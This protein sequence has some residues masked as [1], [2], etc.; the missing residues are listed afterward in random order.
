[1]SVVIRIEENY[2]NSHILSEKVAWLN[3]RVPTKELRVEF[4]HSGIETIET[5]IADVT[6]WADNAEEL[7]I[8]FRLSV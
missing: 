6:I 1:M 3:A 4:S 2:R 5:I 7:E 8:L